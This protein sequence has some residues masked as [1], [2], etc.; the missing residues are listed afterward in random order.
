MSRAASQEPR[1][2]DR[3]A[4]A[5]ADAVHVVLMTVPS[6]DV[7]ERVVRTLVDERLVACG[8]ILPG[9]TSIYRWQGAVQTDPEVL[10]ILKTVAARVPALL[11][12]A[13]ELHPYEVPEVL[14]LPVAA[15]HKPYLQWVRACSDGGRDG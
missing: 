11:E 15:G 13:P 3:R 4:A 8:N 5:P 12:R 1:Q 9:L 10:V 6:A 14:V 7:A 2:D